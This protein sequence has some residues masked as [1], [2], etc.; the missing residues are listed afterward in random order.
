MCEVREFEGKERVKTMMKGVIEKPYIY[1][2][3]YRYHLYDD[4]KSD[5][6]T[7][8]SLSFFFLLVSPHN[9]SKCELYGRGN[10]GSLERKTRMIERGGGVM[11]KLDN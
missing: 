6:G 1:P 9:R 10:K 2:V 5:I 11:D 4:L 8:T 3:P 7:V